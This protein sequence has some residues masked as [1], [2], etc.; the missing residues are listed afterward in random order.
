MAPQRRARWA[1][2]MPEEVSIWMSGFHKETTRDQVALSLASSDSSVAT[3]PA[4]H[5][6]LMDLVASREDTLPFIESMAA[7]VPNDPWVKALLSQIEQGEGM[8]S[9]EVLEVIGLEMLRHDSNIREEVGD[10]RLRK[11]IEARG[12]EADSVRDKAKEA[13]LDLLRREDLID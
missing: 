11:L 13:A 12:Q 3:M 7:G 8:L 2:E 6:V 4:R 5:L 10:R 9:K 1:T